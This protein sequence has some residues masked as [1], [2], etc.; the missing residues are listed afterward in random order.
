MVNLLPIYI[1][2]VNT[3]RAV[4]RFYRMFFQLLTPHFLGKTH[5]I[6]KKKSVR[7]VSVLLHLKYLF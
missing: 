4:L 2:H 3:K 6:L 7:F 1:K 5:D